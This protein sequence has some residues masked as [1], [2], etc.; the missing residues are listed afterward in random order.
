MAAVAEHHDQADVGQ[1]LHRRQVGGP[2]PGRRH[3][4]ARRRRRP[5]AAAASVWPCSAPK[6]FTTRMPATDS[7]TTAASSADSCWMAMAGTWRRLEKRLPIQLRNGRPPSASTVRTGSMKA[8]ITATAATVTT[9]E[10]VRGTSHDE[11][12][13]L[14][15]VG[16]GPAH[17]LAGLVLVVEREVQPLEVGEQAVPQHELGPP[18]LAERQVPAKAGEGGGDHPGAG[19]GEGPEQEGLAV[20]GHDPLVDGG[21]HQ[22]RGGD[23]ADGPEQAHHDPGGDAL[24]LGPHRGADELPPVTTRTRVINGGQHHGS[25]LPR[26]P[27]PHGRVWARVNPNGASR[28]GSAGPA[29]YPG[30]FA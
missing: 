6:P 20:L 2:H 5:R 10:M 7:S 9:L 12:L 24:P 1:Q 22:Q 14:L 19:D 13:H 16:V 11:L 23:L 27:D 18:A 25:N 29:L 4:L 17:E 30:L 26:R 3:G 21:P 28:S 15:Q 8:R